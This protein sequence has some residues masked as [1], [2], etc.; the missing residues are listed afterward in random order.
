M[1]IATGLPLVSACAL[2]A[3]LWADPAAAASAAP[4]APAPAPP[5]GV[6]DTNPA[7]VPTRL[8]AAPPSTVAPPPAAPQP[9]FGLSTLRLLSDKGLISPEEYQ[10]AQKDLTDLAASRAVDSTT[11]TVGKWKTTLYGYAQAD[12]MYHSTQSFPDFSSNFAVARPDTYAAKHGRFSATIRDTRIGLRIQPPSIGSVRVSGVIETDFLGPTGTIGSSISEAGYFVNANLRIRHAFLKMET[13][14]VDVMFGQYWDLFGWQPNYFPT[15][16]QWPGL[17]GELF[18]RTIQLRLSHTFKTDPVNVEIAAAVRSAERDA[19]VPGGQGGLRIVFNKWTAWHTGY[20]TATNL[21]PAS[22]GLSGDVREIRVP[23]FSDKP[24]KSN[25][26]LG[27][28]FAANAYLPIIP[29]KK[30][31]KDNS[32][33]LVGEFV[34]GRAINDMYTGLTGGMA[35]AALPNPTGATPAPTYTSPLDAG[36]AVY[37]AQ[38]RLH[39][40]RWTT[41]LVGLEYYL[42]FVG[43]RAAIFANFSH[44]QLHDA[45]TYANPAKVR[46]HENFYEAGFLVDPH[47]SV[48]FALDYA[49]IDDVYADGVKAKNES[50]QLSGFLFF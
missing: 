21:T 35:N 19:G 20:L 3:V 10:A 4:P 49:H 50:V 7:S 45:K 26:A 33:S 28:G 43:G 25:S 38:G 27:G 14:I 47:E 46:D 37:D 39:L 13:P 17:V 15:V 36:L 29:A 6:V 30:D 18:S 31:K 2:G 9:I 5:S 23:E 41:F 8:V 1:R 40:P 44:S 42:P 24:Q 16:V 32:L 34:T 11:I 22:I 48:R 12:M